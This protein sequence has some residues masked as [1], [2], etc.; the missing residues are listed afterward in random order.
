MGKS[1]FRGTTT[2][3]LDPSPTGFKNYPT[4]FAT[5]LASDL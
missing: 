1:P 3:N 4:I 5:T 2:V